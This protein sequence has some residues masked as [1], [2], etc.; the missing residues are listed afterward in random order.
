MPTRYIADLTAAQFM[1]LFCFVCKIFREFVKS[2]KWIN[3]SLI[4]TDIRKIKYKGMLFMKI[5]TSI[6]PFLYLFKGGER[7]I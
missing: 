2:N 6:G 4:F 1:Y 7:D 5:K 3:E